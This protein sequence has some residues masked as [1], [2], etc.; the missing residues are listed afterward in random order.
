MKE[1]IKG[2]QKPVAAGKVRRRKE[3]S[4]KNAAAVPASKAKGF[5]RR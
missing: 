1:I 3:K 2:A 5:A 4:A